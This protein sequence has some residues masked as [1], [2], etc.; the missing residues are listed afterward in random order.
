MDIKD[1]NKTQLILLTLLITF[2]V[3]IATGIVTVSLMQKM[4]TNAT[5]TINNV[6][7]RTIEKVTTSAPAPT[8]QTGNSNINLS[9]NAV[10]V[11]I[12]NKDFVQ[13]DTKNV[14]AGVVVD[15]MKP[16]TEGV[17][18]SDSGLILVD[19]ANLDKEEN[20]YKVVLGKELFDTQIIKRFSNGFVIMQ[21]K[22][23]TKVIDTTADT[24]KIDQNPVDNS[25]KQ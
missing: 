7:Q 14:P 2:V 6:I 22:S 15:P 3:S 4:P 12:Y 19:S 21:I 1:L 16:T 18:I 5:A 20:I 11:P 25:V 24:K 17:I 9:D 23:K 10:L 8:T 13:V